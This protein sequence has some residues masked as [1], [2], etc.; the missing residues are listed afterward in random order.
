MNDLHFRALLNKKIAGRLNFVEDIELSHYIETNPYYK[1][2]ADS[3]ELLSDN[4]ITF[5]QEEIETVKANWAEF[6][7][8][9]D[10]QE[11]K[12]IFTKRRVFLKRLTIAASFL[13]VTLGIF[14]SVERDTSESIK[15]NRLVTHEVS[16]SKINLPDG[17][18]ILLKSYSKLSYDEKFSP[19]NR[20]INFEGEGFFTIKPDAA[21]P[22]II[23]TKSADVRVLGTVFSL[24]T[25]TDKN[26][27]QA[28]LLKGKIEVSLKSQPEKE[29]ELRPAQ[30][31]T[32]SSQNSAAGVGGLALN[33][34]QIENIQI[35]DSLYASYSDMTQNIDF[36]DNTLQEIAVTLERKYNIKVFVADKV[37]GKKYTGIFKNK[38][39]KY[40]LEK[41][42]LS[43]NFNYN[44]KNDTLIIN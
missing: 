12:L 6:K 9:L 25:C 43:N 2:I 38:E 33:N 42:K 23:H 8:K 4:N 10:Q 21:H 7:K 22:F 15:S 27:F 37:K 18:V 11:N 36:N 39:L 31:I 30:K 20:I 24:S 34:V 28:I 19:A 26:Q 3:V 17:S 13:I 41:L 29:I 5:Q 44:I 16:N 40:V 14:Y 35:T 32:I 1:T